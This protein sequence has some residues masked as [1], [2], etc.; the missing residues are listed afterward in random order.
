MTAWRDAS[1]PD[2]LRRF[3]AAFFRPISD[4]QDRCTA[5]RHV[6][7]DTNPIFNL[8][9]AFRTLLK[10]P[11]VTAVAIVLLEVGIGANV[12]IFS[13]FERM[14]RLQLLLAGWCRE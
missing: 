8:R 11:F 3:R 4:S 9:L 13:L 12:A 1:R 14:V 2:T 5:L 6:P 10:S 7:L